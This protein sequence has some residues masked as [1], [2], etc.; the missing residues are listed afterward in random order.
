M[1]QNYSK[2]SNTQEKYQCK[3]N[4]YCSSVRQSIFNV[5]QSISL[6]KNILTRGIFNATLE[7]WTNHFVIKSS[8]RQCL[9][10]YYNVLQFYLNTLECKTTSYNVLQCI[11][12]PYNALQCI[13][14][15]YQPIFSN[16]L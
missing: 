9:T 11:T 6:T 2:Y 3:T 12:M 5:R 1:T 10:I 13:T 16:F 14:M 15:S 7:A 8:V 4:F